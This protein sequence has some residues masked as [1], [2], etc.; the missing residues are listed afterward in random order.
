VLM[1]LALLGFA[2]A[3]IS[4]LGF[5]CT[6]QATI[7]AVPVCDEAPQGVDE[8]DMPAICEARKRADAERANCAQNIS[9]EHEW[10][11]VMEAWE[12]QRV[13]VSKASRK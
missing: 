5:E 3:Q 4:W 13:H 2:Q 8:S 11:D 10:S 7:L 6:A 12:A 9:C 1:K